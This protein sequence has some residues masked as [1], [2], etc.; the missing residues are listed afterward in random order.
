MLTQQIVLEEKL[1]K[2]SI[3]LI[4]SEESLEKG[5]RKAS[6]LFELLEK[7]SK[8]KIDRL[9]IFGSIKKETAIKVDF[10]FDCMIFIDG[11]LPSY[12]DVVEDFVNILLVEKNSTNITRNPNFVRLELNNTKY[13]IVPATQFSQDPNSQ[14][15]MVMNM[16]GL[17]RLDRSAREGYI[18]SSSLAET[19]AE[20]VKNQS[21]FVH[22]FIR[23]AKFWNKTLYIKDYFSGR[24]STIETIAI[25]VAKEEE[26]KHLTVSVRRAFRVFLQLITNLDDLRIIFEE[27]YSIDDV[28]QYI[29]QQKPLV[30]DPS[31][32]YNNLAYP[33]IQSKRI[34]E[35]FQ[36][37]AAITI[38]RLEQFVSDYSFNSVFDP[39]PQAAPIEDIKCLPHV[40]NWLLTIREE[41]SDKNPA[42]IIRN[43]KKVKRI[44]IEI[45]KH[46]LTK[47]IN[48]FNT[49]IQTRDKMGVE[50]VKI[51]CENILNQS[52]AEIY[53]C[54]KGHNDYHATFEMPAGNFVLIIS[55]KWD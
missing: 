22:N 52:T 38:S 55:I 7:K 17:S 9:G 30:L 24:S 12:D 2:L 14:R 50:I 39:Q 11:V 18:F 20:F 42:V 29:L 40:C 32:P 46:Y 1:T 25:Y 10:D 21:E 4:P 33:F 53:P 41:K 6:K 34:K 31:N 28:N 8:F 15:E 43:D 37:S 49:V 45:I 51:I 13:D 5:I 23:L 19:Q 48:V 26:T 16:I 54:Y 3:K 44:G 27:Y 47:N 36:E 35:N